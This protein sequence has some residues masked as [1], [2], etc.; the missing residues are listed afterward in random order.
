MEEMQELIN[1]LEKINSYPPGMD[2]ISCGIKGVG[3]FPGAKGIFTS[4]NSISEKPIMILGHDFGAKR[5]YDTSVINGKENQAI[6]MWKNLNRLF[7]SHFISKNDCFLTNAIM[8]VR[9]KE[10]AIAPNPTY[11]KH[12]QFVDDCM[13]FLIFQISIQKPKTILVLG[14]HLFDIMSNIS[15]DLM[16]LKGTK[17]FS[18]LDERGLSYFQNIS[19]KN[20]GNYKTNIAFLA[21]PSTHFYDRNVAKRKIGTKSG[22]AAEA[23]MVKNVL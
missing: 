10:S 12:E 13:N 6:W 11:K 1:E 2:K 4:C 18:K 16:I 22:F 5:D 21:H 9:S 20:I 7:E 3:F 17:T 15:S 23:E 8:G 19:I 14:G